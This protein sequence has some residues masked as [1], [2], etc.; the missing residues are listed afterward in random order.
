MTTT[1]VRSAAAT[2]LQA[3]PSTK[4]AESNAGLILAMVIDP[5]PAK[6]VSIFSQ[7]F[8]GQDLAV[9]VKAML[10]QKSQGVGARLWSFGHNGTNW[11]VPSWEIM[12]Q[13]CIQFKAES[14][15]RVQM[16]CRRC[17]ANW[18]TRPSLL[19]RACPSEGRGENPG[20][21]KLHWTPAFAG[22]TFSA[23]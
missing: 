4:N 7:P 12:Q 10:I 9:C 21:S 15:E 6:T 5:L 23:R 16:L 14:L 17:L 3:P 2:M 18:L 20:V 11:K 1:L 8:P 22:V 13:G 19:R